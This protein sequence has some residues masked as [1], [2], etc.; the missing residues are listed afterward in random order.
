[1]MVA[2][3]EVPVPAVSAVTA[4]ATTTAV[5]IRATVPPFAFHQEASQTADCPE[6]SDALMGSPAA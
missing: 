1:M 6:T 4:V 5:A 2:A 3:T